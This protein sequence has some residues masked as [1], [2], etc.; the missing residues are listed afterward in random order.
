VLDPIS[1]GLLSFFWTRTFAG[2]AMDNMRLPS[3][4]IAHIEWHVLLQDEN[5]Y[6]LRE[7]TGFFFFLKLFDESC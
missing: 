1:H 7:G 4:V 2:I 6:H 5:L 3:H